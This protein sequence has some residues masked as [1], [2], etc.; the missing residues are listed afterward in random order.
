M[1]FNTRALALILVSTIALAAPG[2]KGSQNANKPI[3]SEAGQKPAKW[4]AQYRSPASLNYS[5]V[6][7]AV[8]FYS[9]ISVV[10]PSVV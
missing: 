10:S 4:I 1:L 3:T 5:G 8:F 2:C 7:I 9:G 6:N